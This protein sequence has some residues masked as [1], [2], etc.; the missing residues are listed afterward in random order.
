MLNSQD[1]SLTPQERL[2]ALHLEQER[3]TRIE[4]II[5]NCLLTAALIILV[6]VTR[7]FYLEGYYDSLPLP[8]PLKKPV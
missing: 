4:T 5:G 7:H 6:I 8:S 2:N 1:P 3:E